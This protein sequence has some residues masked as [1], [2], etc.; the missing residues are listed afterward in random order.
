M[1]AAAPVRADD[2]TQNYQSPSAMPLRFIHHFTFFPLVCFILFFVLFVCT[3]IITTH[4]RL[5]YTIKMA[6]RYQHNRRCH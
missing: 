6:E 4:R 1:M 5:T 2:V 3:V